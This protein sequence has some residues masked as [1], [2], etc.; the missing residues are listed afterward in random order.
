MSGLFYAG[1]WLLLDML[2][3]VFF[4]VVFSFTNNIYLAT[5]LGIAIGVAQV[6][7]LKARRR[8]VDLMQWMSLG[9]VLV[10]GTATL[11]THNPHFMMVKPTLI[12]V[13]VGL[14]MMKPGWMLRYVPPVAHEL[15]ADLIRG[16]GYVWAGLM[17][18]TAAANL[19]LAMGDPKLWIQFLAI[20][21]LASKLG[22]FAIQYLTMRVVVGARHRRAEQ[23]GGALTDAQAA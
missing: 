8:P 17:F 5:A 23:L 21:P 10:F 18:F 9:L 6:I 16:F 14:V 15:G 12:Y 2:S 13:A 1:K 19:V 22:L 4:L 11:L 3:T 7:Y 20:F